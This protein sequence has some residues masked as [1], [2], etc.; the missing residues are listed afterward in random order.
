MLKNMTLT[1]IA[2]AVGGTLL[3]ANE[4]DTTQ[5]SGAVI[6][7]RLV[8]EG[9]LF[10]A[11]KGERVDGHK[12][13]EDVFEKGAACV[14]VEDVPA[15]PKG[16]YIQV[17]S[18]LQALK[19]VAAFYRKQLSIPIVGI[20]G[21]VGK[22]STKEMIASV[23][24][25][26]YN[27][28]K[29]EGNFNNEIGLPLTILRIREEHEAAVVEM[30]ISDF[31]EMHRLATI[32][33]PDISVITNIG[34]CHLEFLGDRDG[35]L[36]AKTEM[37]DHLTERGTAILNGD[38]DKLATITEVNG[39]KPFFYGVKK[40]GNAVAEHISAY[41]S[42]V[43]GR[44]LEGITATIHMPE[45]TFTVHIGLPGMHNVYNAMAAACVGR[46]LSLTA[47]EIAAGI[48]KATTISGRTNL[49]RLKQNITLIDDCYNA[50]PVSMKEALDILNLA[51]GRS[52]A[53]LGD[54]GE[55]GADEKALHRSVGEHFEH[56]S[57]DVLFTV[58]ELSKEIAAG[59]KK[60]TEKTAIYSFDSKD[61]MIK[62]LLAC[63]SPGDAV[64]VK[65]SH[66]MDFPA[67]VEAVREAFGEK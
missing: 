3:G 8:K 49:I 30:G 48:N 11:V 13:V 5:I 66:F 34:T 32:A 46:E 47:K 39:K 1:N 45:D 31:G 59:A 23:L 64:L 2:K 37:F 19:D 18:T 6:D 7:S 25:Q 44:G 42:N 35:V 27:V 26:K 14:I 24:S 16:P 54:M 43:V 40:Q 17:P 53:V 20:T 56:L 28:L 50:N 63:I 29:T 10:F 4:P 55:L 58:G 52:I 36:K 15:D 41:A 62:E 67:V 21:S 33:Q 65:A 9:F 12:F 38:D 22:T 51:K 57:I 60:V 61:V